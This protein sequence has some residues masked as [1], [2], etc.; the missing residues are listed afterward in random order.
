MQR[1]SRRSLAHKNLSDLT[2]QRLSAYALAATAAGVGVLALPPKMHA[3]IVY[4][5]AHVTLG[6]KSPVTYDLD[7]NHDGVVDFTLGHSSSC[8]VGRC[9]VLVDAYAK[10]SGNAIAF[11][12]K[13]QGCLAMPPGA[14]IGPKRQFY[15]P[16]VQLADYFSAYSGNRASGNWVNVTNHY[17]GLK[18]TIS[19]ETHYGWARL[20]VSV[21]GIKVVGTLTGYAY[22]TVANQPIIAGQTTADETK[23]PSAAQLPIPAPQLGGLGLLAQGSSALAVWRREELVQ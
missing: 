11:G 3:S 16:V 23:E 14:V 5:P 6:P 19:G 12:G 22:E 10:Q 20:N 13:V 15:A 9:V 7:L 1:I 21:Q 8:D 4:T 2:Q 17:L 18:F